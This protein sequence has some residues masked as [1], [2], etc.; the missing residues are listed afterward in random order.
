MPY[1]ITSLMKDPLRT[2][3]QTTVSVP[4]QNILVR[5]LSMQSPTNSLGTLEVM[6]T[7]D[8]TKGI[9]S[10]GYSINFYTGRLHPEVQP[11][12][13]FIYHILAGKVLLYLSLENCIPFT[14]I[15][16]LELCISFN[17]CKL[18]SPLCSIYE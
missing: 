17:C 1:A 4:S 7:E 3:I 16:S 8:S 6:L 2:K 11:L 5:P 14:M 9:F 15:L 12:T 13:P 18:H 10:G